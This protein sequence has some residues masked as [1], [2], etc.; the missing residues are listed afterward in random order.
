[1]RTNRIIH[2]S[3]AFVLVLAMS[4]CSGDT[5]SD[6]TNNYP[7]TQYVSDGNSGSISISVENREMAIGSLTNFGV[8]V[9]NEVGAPVSGIVVAC[10]SE[11]GV[12]ILE[13]TTGREITDQ[14]GSISGK[15]GCKYPGSYQF[16]CRL[17]VGMNKRQL[18]GIKCTGDIPEGFDGFPG[19]AGGGLGTG[20]SD[21]GDTGGV[22]GTN[23]SGIRI[24]GVI[25]STVAGDSYQID[26][27]QDVCKDGSAEPF[28]D[29]FVKL[30]V[31]N[32]T[33]SIVRFNKLY[34][35]VPGGG[36]GGSTFVSDAI[37]FTC[38]AEPS[39]GTTTCQSLFV[40]AKG[41][42]TNKTFWGASSPVGISGF[43]NITFRLK[44]IIE[45]T[46]EEVSLTVRAGFAFADYNNCSS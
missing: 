12:A 38:S 43:R 22:G 6:G 20:G 36:T 13:P 8:T 26:L 4:A 23:P 17:P 14:W 7:G 34:Y 30:T 39:G 28:T 31:V 24:T 45:T 10:D 9:K 1:M 21:V 11:L 27:K 29:D 40:Q 42:T 37:T 3:L 41:T 15:I 16:A 2:S 19:A 44:G 25:G 32:N 35:E 5:S 46:G 18:V 33:N